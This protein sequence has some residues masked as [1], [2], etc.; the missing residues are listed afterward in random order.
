MRVAALALLL[1]ACG[2]DDFVVKPGIIQFYEEPMLIEAPTSVPVGS[3][4]TVRVATFGGGC[5]SLE[6]TTVELVEDGAIVTPFDR[7][8]IP[9]ENEACTDPLLT[10]FHEASLSFSSPGSKIVRIHGRRVA[11]D[12]DQELEIPYTIVAN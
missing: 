1:G 11:G 5:E 12:I 6:D 9:G 4:F 10:F 2:S 7:T 8:H 3:S